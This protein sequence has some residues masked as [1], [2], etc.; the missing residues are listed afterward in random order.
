LA[1]PTSPMVNE[2]NPKIDLHPIV[3]QLDPSPEQEI[4]ILSRGKDLVVT[5]GAGT[6]KTRT[7]VARY[8]SLLTEG[9]PLRSIV[10]ITFTTKAAREMRNRIREEVRKY[11]LADHLS[12]QERDDWGSVYEGLDAARIS[13]IHSLAGDILRQHP[14]ELKLDPQFELLDEGE[15]ARMKSLAVEAALSWAG[16]DDLA[17]ALFPVFGAWRLRRVLGE[18]LNKRLDTASALDSTPGDLWSFWEPYLIEPLKNFVEDPV[19]RSGLDGLAGLKYDGTMD[20]AQ[21]A[22]DLL[23][24]DLR[25]VIN[26]WENI[27]EAIR[28]KDWT[29]VSRSIGPLG[30]HLKQ[31]GKGENWAPAKP[32][33]VIKELQTIYQ[34][35]IGKSELNLEVDRKLAT[36]VIPA[37]RA[38]FQYANQWYGAAKDQINGLDFDDLEGKILLLFDQYPDVLTYWQGEIQALLVDEYQDTNARQRELVNFLAGGQNHLFI[39]GDGKQSIYRFRGADVAVFRQEQKRIGAEGKSCHL[40]TS[41]RSHSQLLENLNIMLAP[42][43]GDA[44]DLPYLEPFSELKP[45]RLKPPKLDLPAYVEVHLA[46]GNKAAGAENLAAEAVAARMLEILGP[47]SR[48]N[49]PKG[50]NFGDIAVLCRASSSFSAFEG[51][52]EKAGIPYTTVSGQGFFERPEIRDVLNALQVFA[53]PWNDLALAG[54]MRSPVS[55]FPD[56]FLLDVREFQRS[57]KLGSLYE[58]AQVFA[59]KQSGEDGYDLNSFILMVDELSTLAGR[60]TAAELISRFLERTAYAAGMTLAGQ[61]RSVSNLRKLVADAQASGMVNLT[62]FLNAIEEIRNVA[63]REGEAQFV[64]EGAVQI[65]TVHQAKGLEF[66]IVI[67]GDA[68]KR[69]R[70]SRDIL[71]DDRFGLIPPFSIQRVE[72]DNPG[73]FSIVSE[74]SF[75]YE[76]ALET[77]RLKEEA[78]TNRLLYVAA[79]RAQDLLII[80]GAAGNPTRDQKLPSLAGWMGKLAGPMGLAECELEVDRNGSRIHQM[81]IENPRLKV[82]LSVYERLVEFDLSAK[83]PIKEALSGEDI[84]DPAIW[85]QVGSRIGPAESVDKVRKPIFPAAKTGSSSRA[86]SRIIGDVVHHALERWKFPSDGEAEFIKWA[87]VEFKTAGIYDSQA[88][89]SGYRRV[90]QILERFSAT[91]LFMRMEQA[92]IILHEVPYSLPGAKS[93]FEAGSIDALFREEGEWFLV[94][95]KT[96]EIRP[97]DEIDWSSVDYLQQVEN[98][99]NAAGSLL[100]QKLYPILCFLDYGGQ[101]KLVTDRW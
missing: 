101:I 52:F 25:I 33:S 53:D 28:N 3:Q 77:E 79:T 57:E 16:G 5:A 81:Q 12:E 67:L 46:V 61:E 41:Y 76:I 43:L 4:P 32:R 75:A 95:F 84:V 88:I 100:E 63:V 51:A 73:L 87:E 66:P 10:A 72:E 65:M 58:A 8:L 60:V 13:T 92:E 27:Q 89:K 37:L 86:P 99:I 14:A 71:L 54:L 47:D 97:G 36:E 96:D 80:S 18:L 49:R 82:N 1:L 2:M 70:F 35:K 15:S 30:D 59:G 55:G 74:K 90:R 48:S 62:D 20:R 22:G 98:Y 50:V 42:V 40:D 21:S 29:Q 6:G 31:K 44:T 34:E 39:V 38:I 93:S 94:E 45:G 91:D 7:L 83:A 69:E 19:V 64:S 78:E 11:L 68:T 24:E 26:K 85:N 23:V 17:S 9:V 56:Q